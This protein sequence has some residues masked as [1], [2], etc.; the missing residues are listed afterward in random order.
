MAEVAPGRSTRTRSRFAAS[1]VIVA[2]AVAGA[3]GITPTA[4][5]E[6]GD[7]VDVTAFSARAAAWAAANAAAREAAIERA[8][9]LGE[10]AAAAEAEAERLAALAAATTT[11]TTTTAPPT[12]TTVAPTTTTTTTTVAPAT[13]EAPVDGAEPAEDPTTTT[14]TEPPA[15]GPT[16]E[17][18]EA[19]RQCES[20]GRYDALSPGGRYRGAYQFSQA[21]W[22][23]VASWANPALVGVDPAAASVADQDAQAQALYDRQG[24]GPWPTCGRHLP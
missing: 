16:A 24:S 21:T 9:E 11:T 5:Q 17:Q 19:L 4:A 13:T 3:I 8:I 22:D 23:W 7:E 12:T 15:G 1:F 6:A 20:G 18:W 10:E 2:L 14:T